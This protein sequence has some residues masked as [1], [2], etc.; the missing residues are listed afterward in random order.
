MSEIT[1]SFC[2]T[3]VTKE[4]AK[5]RFVAGADAFICRDCV[6]TCV[7]VLGSSDADW[8]DTLIAKLRHPQ[9]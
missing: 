9:G 5:N 3:T 2:G 4:N 8:P 7:S 1:C 6:E